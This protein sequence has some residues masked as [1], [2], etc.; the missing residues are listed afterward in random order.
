[1]IFL[2]C[3]VNARVYQKVGAG[4]ALPPP[5]LGK[6][7]YSCVVFRSFAKLVMEMPIWIQIPGSHPT[8]VFPHLENYTLLE[9]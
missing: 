2:S 5:P 9:L 1:V 4:P 3:K 8:K 6:A 7:N